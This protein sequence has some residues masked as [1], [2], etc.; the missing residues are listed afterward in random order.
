MPAPAVR[1]R[2]RPR[3]GI[4]PAEP[5][6][7]PAIRSRARA[8]FERAAATPELFYGQLA[9]ERLGRIVPQPAGTPSLLRHRRPAPG[10]QQK[11]LV[12]AVK[13]L[14]QQGLRPNRP[15][16]SAPCPRISTATRSGCWRSS[17]RRRSAG[18]TWRCGPPVRRATPAAPSITRRPSRPIRPSVPSGRVLVAGPRH[19]PPGIRAS[20]AAAVSHAN[21]R[22]HDAAD[23][24]HRARA[25]RQ[26][27]ASA[28]TMAG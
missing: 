3:A 24:R 17:W 9:L 8:Y 20:T 14:G 25:G 27:G 23:A 26:D 5:R 22:G 13:L 1:C 7:K 19:H 12:R 16:S 10:I 28:M 21:A 4:G 18:R 2:S 6:R 11:R 15:C